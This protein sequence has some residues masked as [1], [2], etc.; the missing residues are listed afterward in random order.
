MTLF[1]LHSHLP[2]TY[3]QIP[4]TTFTKAFAP[5]LH[6]QIADN[7]R[8]TKA[9]AL[10]GG[11]VHIDLSW[12]NRPKWHEHLRQLWIPKLLWQVVDEEVAAI[13]SFLLPRWSQNAGGWLVEG[14]WGS[15]NG[16]QKWIECCK[17]GDWSSFRGKSPNNKYEINLS[18]LRVSG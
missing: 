10:V 5:T 6:L 17:C 18:N 4:N 15:L 9:L 7:R 2:Y 14:G 3:V 11:S 13:G 1:S 8:L 12:N 16:S